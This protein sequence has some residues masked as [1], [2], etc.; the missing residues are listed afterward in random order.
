MRDTMQS[1]RLLCKLAGALQLATPGSENVAWCLDV[2]QVQ[3]VLKAASVRRNEGGEVGPARMHQHST[4]AYKLVS[5]LAA[6][7]D[8]FRHDGTAGV[9]AH[10]HGVLAAVRVC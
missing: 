8:A 1:A 2:R 10:L 3:A 4:A 9:K 5:W 7:D 6:T